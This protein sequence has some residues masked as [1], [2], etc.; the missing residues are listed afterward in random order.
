M[1]FPILLAILLAP[2]VA[3]LILVFI[4]KEENILIKCV[5]AV[6][7]VRWFNYEHGVG[8]LLPAGRSGHVP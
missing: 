4:P 2:L 1:D 6:A 5:A 3:S 7:S 8:I